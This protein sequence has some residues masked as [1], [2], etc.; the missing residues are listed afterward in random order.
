MLGGALLMF[1]TTLAPRW[2]GGMGEKQG[3]STGQRPLT[4][5]AGWELVR[6]GWEPMRAGWKLTRA[7][8]ELTRAGWE[9]TR[10]G[11]EL[12]RAGW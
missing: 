4:T 3:W 6:A 10:A 11:W 8:W 7:S 5:R 9:L 2:G 12:M 1:H